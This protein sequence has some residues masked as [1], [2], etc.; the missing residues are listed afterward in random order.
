MKILPLDDALHHAKSS[1]I[2]QDSTP[3]DAYALLI[4]KM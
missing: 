3:P 4:P 2:S 1:D